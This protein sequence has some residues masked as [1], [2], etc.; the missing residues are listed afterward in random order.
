M[1][2]FLHVIIMIEYIY[3]IAH[4][5]NTLVNHF[6]SFYKK[7]QEAIFSVGNCVLFG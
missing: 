7:C 1:Y 3:Y 5:Q 2:I 4:V 6:R